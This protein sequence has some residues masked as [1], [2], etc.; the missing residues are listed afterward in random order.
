MPDSHERGQGLHTHRRPND[1]AAAARMGCASPD[2][3]YE[4]PRDE[5]W[6]PAPEVPQTLGRCPIDGTALWSY[7]VTGKAAC[8]WTGHVYEV[9][10]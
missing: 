5:V 4:D 3:L 2:V 10:T 8:E 9:P 7:G 1:K 6:P